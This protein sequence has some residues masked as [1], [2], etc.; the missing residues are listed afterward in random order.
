MAFRLTRVS[1]NVFVADTS[2][3]QVKEI[4]AA[5]GY[6]TVNILQTGLDLP[7]SVVTDPTGNLFVAEGGDVCPVAYVPGLCLTIN[8]SLIE[9]PAASGYTT[10][11]TLASGIFG[12]PFGLAIDGSGNVYDGDFG[13]GCPHEFFAGSG[14]TTNTILCSCAGILDPEGIAIQGNGNIYLPD[15][16]FGTVVK[17]DLV[18]QFPITFRTPAQVGQTDT[19]DGPQYFGVQNNGNAPLTFTAITLSDPSF[20]FYA[21]GTTCSTSTP[22]APGGS[23]LVAVSFQPLATGLH[24]ATVTLTDNNLNQAATTQAFALSADA[25]APAPVILT[26]PANPTAIT[27]A[28]FTFSDTQPNVTFVCSVDALP[29]GACASGVVYPGLPGG[30]HSFQVKAVDTLG[31][32]SLATVYN[33]TVTSAV[34]VAA[35]TITSG[36][37]RTTNSTTAAFTFTDTQAGV[38]FLCS[39]DGIAFTAC[40][41]GISYSITTTNTALNF[42]HTFAVEAQD[43]SGNLSQPASYPWMVTFDGI[44]GYPVDMGTVPVG[45]TSAP[46]TVTINFNPINSSP[47]PG[48][49]A[50]IIAT[51]LGVTGLDFAVSNPGTCAVGTAITRTTICT[52][53][54]TFSPKSAGRR[55]G[56]VILLDAAGNAIADAYLEGIGTAPQITFTPYTTVDFNVLPPQNN[57]NPGTNLTTSV[58]DSTVDGAGN[59]YVT[60][61][62]ISSVD[63]TISQSVGDIWKFPAGCTSAACNVH[64]ATNGN[65]STRNA[66]LLLPDGLA[67]D[68]EG[69]LWGGNYSLEPFEL[70][71]VYGNPTAFTSWCEFGDAI[72]ARIQLQPAVDGAGAVSFVGSG[73][74]SLCQQELGNVG[75]P[76]IIFQGGGGGGNAGSFD[77][78]TSA[79]SLAVDPQGNIFVADT[80]NNAVKEVLASSNYSISRIVG[81][82]FNSPISVA[83]DSFGNIFVSDA[84]NGVIKEMTAASGYTTILTIAPFNFGAQV[85]GNNLKVDAL[86]NVYLPNQVSGPLGQL[87]KLDFSDAPAPTFPPQPRLRPPPIPPTAR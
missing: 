52:L 1:G 66:A 16:V 7:W 46:Q 23:C 5:S 86:G 57:A 8:T 79:N 43:G 30:P 20:Q 84:G 77:F 65:S 19:V 40:S 31:H 38:S 75:P 17:M 85:N 14:Y 10:V 64:V 55:K 60:D 59:V 83:S 62:L 48:P 41:S 80:G 13:N 81:S 73:I 69:T 33:W 70:P 4:L 32:P 54:V 87:V 22:L 28:T 3:G 42:Y 58:S 63:G 61:L 71:T 74:L 50:S 18:D 21:T 37:A 9:I 25:I 51:S 72:G 12:K 68:G 2:N 29:F 49:V 45:Q 76:I 24:N 15:V 39:L 67:I 53:Q 6:T 26:N 36:P 27:S 11:N 34:T 47:D 44:I 56:G 78:S 35:P 82:G